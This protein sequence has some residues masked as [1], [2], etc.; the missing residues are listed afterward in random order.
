MKFLWLILLTL[1]LQ[2]A[3][4]PLV[5]VEAEKSLPYSG[6]YEG[7]RL[8]KNYQ[9][10][11]KETTLLLAAYI[12]TQSIGEK[13]NRHL[14][15]KYGIAQ[16]IVTRLKY[17]Y[18]TTDNLADYLMK[19]SRTIRTALSNYFWIDTKEYYSQQCLLAAYNTLIGNI[20]KEF[21]VGIATRCLG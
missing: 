20:P 14:G 2:A 11:L 19:Y 15:D 6:Y 4:L 18:G 13:T 1:K 3:D 16:V 8:L 7:T 10:D 12:H 5:I 9:G 21:D 17:R